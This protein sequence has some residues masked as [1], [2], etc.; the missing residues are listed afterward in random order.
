M[1]FLTSLQ[2]LVITT[3]LNPAGRDTYFSAQ[4]MTVVWYPLLTA[5]KACMSV[6][7]V[8]PELTHIRAIHIPGNSHKE[9]LRVVAQET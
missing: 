1:L 2:T 7:R 3:A 9:T 6:Y 5:V 8:C 4:E